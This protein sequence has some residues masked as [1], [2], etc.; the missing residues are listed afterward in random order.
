MTTHSPATHDVW[1]M[2]A[3]QVSSASINASRVSAV[4]MGNN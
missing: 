1:L 3:L 2:V 4:T